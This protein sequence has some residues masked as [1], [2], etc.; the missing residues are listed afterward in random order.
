M[1]ERDFL[2]G[3]NMKVS[4]V[5]Q[6]RQ[7]DRRAIEHYGIFEDL[8]ME[9][10]GHAV[11]FMI[12]ETFPYLRGKRFVIFCGLGNNGGDG[13]VVARKLHSN[14][15][16]VQVFLLG[17]PEKYK[18][19]A[20]KN[21]EIV[22]RLSL[23]VKKLETVDSATYA[24]AHGDAVV[25]AMLGTGLSRPLAGLYRD[26]VR[27]VNRAGK[28][29]FSVDIPSGING[30][31]GEIMGE[32]VRADATA[33]F[34]LPK[35]GNLLYPGFEYGGRLYVTHISFPPD[36]YNSTEV[37]IE[38]GIPA[39]IPPRAPDSHKGDYGKVLF[40]AGAQSYLGAPQFSALSFLKA[41]GGLSYLAAPKGVAPLLGS[42]SRE[43]VLYPLWETDTGSISA[44]NLEGL[45][46]LCPRM[47]LV[48]MGP[49]VSLD[50]QTQ[51]L[52][53]ILAR[54]IPVPL[55]LDGDGITAVA[56]DP[57]AL[58]RRVAPTVLTPHPG[59]MARLTGRK[60]PEIVK[61]RVEILQRTSRALRSTIVLKGAHSLVGTPD[62]RV[63]INLSGNAG[64]ATAGSG[65]VLTGIIAAMACRGLD[66]DEAVRVG[67]F[68]HGLAGDLAVGTRGE[69]GMTAD[70]I[71]ENIPAAVRA[72]RERYEEFRRTAYHKV[73]VI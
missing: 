14:G 27:A 45:R 22:R 21:Y 72:Y 44:Q 16:K 57:E 5:M 47:D 26:V 3:D 49:G 42:R 40:I 52:V 43:L 18:G 55:L 17:D 30:D 33:T 15:A 53:R 20:R 23:P 65:D 34:G 46:G 50:E 51:D 69:D 67:V 60:I 38:T 7:M 24:L 48:V 66:L 12:L 68:L 11:Y 32:A 37:K 4:T 70:D 56:L 19:A 6:M 36:I 71:L 2:W 58:S 10:A 61:N 25:D 29:V 41:G 63:W 31:T 59:E 39:P 35:L 13:L 28:T 8:L 54:D 73:R 9:N 62:G 1:M 64:M